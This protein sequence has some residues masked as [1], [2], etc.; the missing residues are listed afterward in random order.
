MTFDPQPYALQPALAH[1]ITIFALSIGVAIVVGTVL[2]LII[3]GRFGPVVSGVGSGLKD[4]LETS[5]RRVLALAQLTVREA[6]RRKALYVFFVFALL[7]MFGGWFLSD[8]TRRD[9]LQI[10]VYVSFVLTAISWLMLPLM[11]LLACWSVPEDIK[12]RSMHTVVTKP[13]R[14]SEIVIGRILGFLAVSTLLLT[15]M[16]GIGYVWIVRLLEPDVREQHLVCRVPVYGELYFIDREG[17]LKREGSNVGDPWNFRSYVEGATRARAVFEFEGVEPGPDGKLILEARFE[18]FRSYKGDMNRGLLY[19]YE[20]VNEAKGLRIPFSKSLELR[21]FGENITEIDREISHYDADAQDFLKYDLYDD[22][23]EDGKLRIE[24]SCLDATQ[25]IGMARPD[26]FIRL[27]D[28]PFW[29]G[30]AKS[31]SGIWLTMLLVIAIGVAVSCFCKGPIASLVTFTLLLVGLFFRDFMQTI[32]SGEFQGGGAI[33]SSVRLYMHMNPQQEIAEGISTTVMQRADTTL[34]NG[35]SLM[36][37]VIPNFTYFSQVT[38]YVP[39]GFDVNWQASL[40]PS[41]LTTL[42]YLLPCV[43]LGYYSLKL[44]ELE[45]K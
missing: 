18:A 12:A 41:L 32:V 7:F 14:R 10:K 43:L 40:L 16:G 20:F 30:F 9:D 15:L 1:W 22:L 25:Y 44:R 38:Q 27:P 29:W 3:T 6:V 36:L 34:I 4:L 17:S 39:N 24:V 8:V 31:I 35:L 33:E 45:S 37:N 2:S 28:S 21:E 26:L 19:R 5:P 42:A 13:A 11:L 23:V